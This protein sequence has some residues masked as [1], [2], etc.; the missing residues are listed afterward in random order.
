MAKIPA[1]VKE[2]AGKCPLWSL[3][4]ASKS[5]KPNVVT[6]LFAKIISDDE[7][8]FVDNFMDKTRKNMAE[9]PQVAATFWDMNS[10]K[11]YQVKGK[12]TV[13][14]SGKVYEDGAAWAKS[15]IPQLPAK[16]VVVVKVEEIFNTSP[17]ADAGKPVY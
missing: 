12:A 5:G 4:T 9:N 1:E 7:C 11:G 16:A 6:I 17:G 14:T 2:I 10:H 8:L 3:A 15:K 13:L